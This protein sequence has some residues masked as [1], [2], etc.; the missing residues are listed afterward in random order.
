MNYLW[1]LILAWLA[2]FTIYDW[3]QIGSPKGS[4]RI[5]TVTLVWWTALC[6][7]S[8]T[9]SVRLIQSMVP[10]AVGLCGEYRIQIIQCEPLLTITG[11]IWSN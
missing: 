11:R 9:E 2:G 4:S 6:E 7:L 5:A 1:Y 8:S 3:F 10:S